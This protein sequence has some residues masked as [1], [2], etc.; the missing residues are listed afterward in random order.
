MP[1]DQTEFDPPPGVAMTLAPGLVRVLAP[2]PSPMTFR[3]TNTYLLGTDK[4]CIID[5]GPDDPAHLAALL[6]A[7]GTRPVSHIILT[8]SHRDHC[9]G[10]PALR[11][12]TGAPLLAFGDSSAGRS[13][14]MARLAASGLLRAGKGVDTS[15]VPDIRLP[16]GAEIASAEWRLRCLHTPGHFGNHICLQ[17]DDMIFSGDHAMGWATSLIA[18]PDGDLSDY[19]GSCDRLLALGPLRLLPGHGAPVADGRARLRALVAHRRQRTAEILGALAQGP[20]TPAALVAAIYTSTPAP[21]RGA[22]TQNVLAHLV[23]LE[24]RKRIRADPGPDLDA[25]YELC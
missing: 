14:V 7:I 8:H 17:W 24:T 13:A 6:A 21:L 15:F 11:R 5:P 12:A 25:L 22:A 16:D 23:D 3:G 9:A 19:L 18:P 20:K 4:L 1:G 10:A 2:N